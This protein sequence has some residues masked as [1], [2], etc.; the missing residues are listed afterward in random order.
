VLVVV[1]P[2]EVVM[3]HARA[4][5][6]GAGDVAGAVHALGAVAATVGAG[7]GRR[8]GAFATVGAGVLVAMAVVGAVLAAGGPDILRALGHC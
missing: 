8:L 1:P 6:L 7:G 5:V 2:V 3:T 4:A